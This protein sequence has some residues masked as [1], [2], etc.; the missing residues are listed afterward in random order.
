MKHEA[1]K[2]LIAKEKKNLIKKVKYI[3]LKKCSS[4]KQLTSWLKEWV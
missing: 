1:K 3:E 4:V 2:K